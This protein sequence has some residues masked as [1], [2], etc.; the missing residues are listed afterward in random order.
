MTSTWGAP[1]IHGE[2][3]KLGFELSERSVSRWASSER[4]RFREA[5]ADVSQK[6]SRGHRC[7]G[8]LH[9][10]NAQFGV[11][12]CFF[13]IG[14]DRR[15]I[16]HFN[17]TRNPNVLWVVQQLREAWAYKQ[18]HRFLLFDRDAKFG[19]EVVS[20]VRDMGSEPTRTAFRSPW[21]N[22]VAERWVGGCRRDLLAMSF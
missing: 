22:G 3:L 1:R 19:A 9:R 15:K 12:Y 5:M 10:P 18:P 8:F 16:L 11:P 13:V 7:N 17:V 4:S 14:H 20:A 6:P 2:L 21:Q